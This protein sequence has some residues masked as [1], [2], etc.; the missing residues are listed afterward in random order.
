M[1]Y[2]IRYR[3]KFKR[4]DT[5]ISK[6]KLHNTITK[7][8]ELKDILHLS[9][10]EVVKL[11][12]I[13]ERYPMCITPYYLSLID[14]DNPND[15]IKKMCIPSIDE[16]D[17]S[18]SFDTSG[19]GENTII[20]GV[21]H[22]YKQT[23]IVLSTNHC[24]MYCRHCFRKRLVGLSDEEIA[25]H[26]EEMVEYIKNHK[27]ISNVL[28]SGGDSFLNSNKVIE[29]YLKELCEIEHLDLI[30]FGTR[31]PVVYPERITK[32]ENLKEILKKY[33]K[34]KQIY[35]VTQFNHPNEVTQEATN[36]VASLREAGVTVKNQTVLL[37]G[38]NDDSQVLGSLLKKITSIGIIPYYVFQCRPVTGVKNQFQVPLKEAIDIV[39]GAKNLQNGQG[40]CFRYCMSTVRGKVE[41]LGKVEENKILFKYHQAKYEEDMGKIFVREVDDDQAWLD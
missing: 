5:L 34:K 16:T 35:V 36:A 29:K 31:I 19:E 14:F 27:E 2:C 22:K 7:A 32:D 23:V 38:V 15:P 11:D 24:A 1:S 18:G 39:E 4:G 28:I 13:L 41:I 37:K 30:R 26:F 9:N 6:E 17:L 3:Q 33:S 10:E 8:E 40:K 12:D 21:Q 20:T 25:S